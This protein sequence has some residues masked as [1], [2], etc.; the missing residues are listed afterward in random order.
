M[1]DKVESTVATFIHEKQ[2]KHAGR[3]NIE[4][5]QVQQITANTVHALVEAHKHAGSKFRIRFQVPCSSP[6]EGLDTEGN[7]VRVSRKLGSNCFCM[8]STQIGGHRGT[9]LQPNGNTRR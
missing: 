9:P 8:F 5:G 7:L 4:R 6:E 1:A 2:R 3:R